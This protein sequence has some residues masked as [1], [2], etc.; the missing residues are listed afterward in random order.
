MSVSLT[1][2]S[3]NVVGKGFLLCYV[4][5]FYFSYKKENVFSF[6]HECSFDLVPPLVL[7][8]YREC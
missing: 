7:C 1:N 3:V 5:V 2:L 8:C 6:A 4:F